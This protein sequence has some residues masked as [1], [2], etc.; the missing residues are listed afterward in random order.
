MLLQRKKKELDS[1]PKIKKKIVLSAQHTSVLCS[2]QI[3]LSAAAALGWGGL[4]CENYVLKFRNLPNNPPLVLVA[5]RTPRA[6]PVGT[7]Q[8]V[9]LLVHV[10]S[11]GLVVAGAASF[12]PRRIVVLLVVVD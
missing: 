10:E 3:R 7:D 5:R 12:L 4:K 8:P 11:A 6:T 9:V 1:P 2:P